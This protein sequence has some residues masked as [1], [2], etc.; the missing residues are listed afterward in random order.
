VLG[1]GGYSSY[2][3]KNSRGVRGVSKKLNGEYLRDLS[4]A[5]D[6]LGVCVLMG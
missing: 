6:P 5:S 4:F 3:I 2:L 1:L